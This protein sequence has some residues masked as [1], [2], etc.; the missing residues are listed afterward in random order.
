MVSIFDDLGFVC[1]TGTKFDGMKRF[2][3]RIAVTEELMKIGHYV[4]KEDNAMVVPI[5]SRSKGIFRYD[6]SAL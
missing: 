5:C 6:E 3:A 2:D 4:K 1:N